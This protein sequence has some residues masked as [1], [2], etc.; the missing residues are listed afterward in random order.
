MDSVWFRSLENPDVCKNYA[1]M[2]THKWETLP[3]SDVT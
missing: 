1:K 2:C 3:L